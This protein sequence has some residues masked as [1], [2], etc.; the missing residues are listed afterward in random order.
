MEEKERQKSMSLYSEDGEDQYLMESMG[1]VYKMD[2]DGIWFVKVPIVDGEPNRDKAVM[3][4][5]DDDVID[6]EED[7]DEYVPREP[8]DNLVSWYESL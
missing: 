5:V 4:R 2:D 3:A 7:E 8:V 6:H 1:V